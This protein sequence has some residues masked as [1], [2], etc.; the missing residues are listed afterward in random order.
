M[1]VKDLKEKLS[2]FDDNLPISI[3]IVHMN[4]N[5]WDTFVN[6][7]IDVRSRELNRVG[8][9]AMLEFWETRARI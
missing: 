6:A 1:T 5:G 3:C 9:T 4:G 8:E 2:A 7:C